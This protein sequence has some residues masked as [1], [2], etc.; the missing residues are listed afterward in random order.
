[1]MRRHALPAFLTI[2]ILLHGIVAIAWR[3]PAR[4]V[5]RLG[6]SLRVSLLP[7]SPHRVRQTPRT[8]NGGHGPQSR[9]GISSPVRDTHALVR[10]SRARR[11][12]TAGEQAGQTAS[13]KKAAR[14]SARAQ[15]SVAGKRL[16]HAL[17]RY[18]YYPELAIR[19]G[20]QG[21]VKI[22]V[23]LRRDGTVSDVHLVHSSG[24]AVLDDA[25]LR[26][27]RNIHSV[28]SLAGASTRDHFDVQLPV[29]YRLAER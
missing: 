3:G 18:F 5:P 13:K 24:Y 6:T 25:A 19:Y 2:S 1:M 22:G 15:G 11:D 23:R 26:S 29:V 8:T 4:P 10:A 20:W 28:G 12:T 16:R 17:S 14:V 27:T 9:S 21:T 7:P